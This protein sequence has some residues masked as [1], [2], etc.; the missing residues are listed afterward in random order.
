MRFLRLRNK[1]SIDRN[2]EL[3]VEIS[4]NLPGWLRQKI[5][6]QHKMPFYNLISG[7]IASQAFQ[8]AASAMKALHKV[9]LIRFLFKFD[10][11]RL[12]TR[13]VNVTQHDCQHQGKSE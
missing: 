7:Q 4:L 11:Y 12:A 10:W 1:R 2:R 8:E 3:Q 5:C 6:N 13:K 9:P